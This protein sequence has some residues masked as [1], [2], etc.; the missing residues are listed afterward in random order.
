MLG[1]RQPILKN[2]EFPAAAYFAQKIGNRPLRA[3]DITIPVIR[4]GFLY[5]GQALA[6]ISGFF[7]RG[8]NFLQIRAAFKKQYGNR[9]LSSKR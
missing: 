4:S 9:A 6:V 2:K 3:H 5:F 1:G 7:W 8:K